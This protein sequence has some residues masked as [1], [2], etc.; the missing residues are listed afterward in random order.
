MLAK[1]AHGGG[2]TDTL[3]SELFPRQFGGDQGHTELLAWDFK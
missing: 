1:V 3:A 2:C